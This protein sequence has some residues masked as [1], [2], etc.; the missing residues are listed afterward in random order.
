MSA[1]PNNSQSTNDASRHKKAILALLEAAI[2]CGR[3]VVEAEAQE[4]LENAEAD[5]LT[6]G[7]GQAAASGEGEINVQEPLYHDASQG[8]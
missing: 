5:A 6:L 8:A 4:K 7:G 3:Q 1:Q 2:E